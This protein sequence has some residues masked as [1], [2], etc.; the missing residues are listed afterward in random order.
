MTELLTIPDLCKLPDDSG[1]SMGKGPCVYFLWK[2]PELLYI[3]ATT[4]RGTRITRHY[5]EKRYAYST[6]GIEKPIPFDRVTFFNC[7]REELW[8]LE[9]AYQTLYQAPYNS[10]A[11]Q[12]RRF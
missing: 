8:D 4:D 6:A 7:T 11:P 2:G 3:G 1:E 12:C 5:R 10:W 9:H